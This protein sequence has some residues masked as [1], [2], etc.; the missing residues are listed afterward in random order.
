MWML[1]VKFQLLFICFF[2]FLKKISEI[3]KILLSFLP[4]IYFGSEMNFAMYFSSPYNSS[5]T[6]TSLKIVFLLYAVML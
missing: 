6:W 5:L 3:I 2:F 4:W 1:E